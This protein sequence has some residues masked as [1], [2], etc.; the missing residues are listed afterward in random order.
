MGGFFI[1][2]L[3]LLPYSLSGEL[4]AA[5][6]VDAMGTPPHDCVL[7]Q[8]WNVQRVMP[9]PGSYKAHLHQTILTSVCSA[10]SLCKSFVIFIVCPVVKSSSNS[11]LVF[12]VLFFVVVFWE[13][14]MHSLLSRGLTVLTVNICYCGRSTP[15]WRSLKRAL[16]H[17]FF[18]V[19][20]NRALR[21]FRFKMLTLKLI[22]TQ[23][24]W[25]DWFVTI[26]LKDAYFHISILPHHW[27]FLRFAFGG[28][29]YQYRFFLSA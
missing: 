27:K 4:H 7:K 19:V 5:S 11:N 28:D 1:T 2:I 13:Q 23:I 22:V 17:A 15:T 3:V 6:G 14:S 10:S 18:F 8:V 12:V 29:D 26:D 25:V 9:W 21:T 20:L 24:K 16:R